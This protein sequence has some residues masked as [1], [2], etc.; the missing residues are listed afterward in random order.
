ME[1]TA[2]EGVREAA[3]RT[4]RQV[5]HGDTEA[6]GRMSVQAGEQRVWRPRGGKS[7]RFWDS[8]E[9]SGPE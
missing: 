8:R 4:S 6:W 2:G 7:E 9:A 1:A 3:P 5:E